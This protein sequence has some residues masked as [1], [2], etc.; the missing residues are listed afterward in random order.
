MIGRRLLR[1][2]LA[3]ARIVGQFA[4]ATPPAVPTSLSVFIDFVTLLEN[5]VSGLPHARRNSYVR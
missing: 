4:F 5:R 3:A 1:C 2:V